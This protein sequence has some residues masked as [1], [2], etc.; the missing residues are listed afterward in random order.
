MSNVEKITLVCLPF[1]G[2]GASFFQEWAD[3]S[4]DITIEAIQ[5][6][7]R[8]KRF[9]EPVYTDVRA[10]SK[11]IFEEF[12][13]NSN[14][15]LNTPLVLFGHSLGAVLAFEV[16]QRFLEAK[17]PLINL[18]VS[19]SPDP[20]TLRTERATGLGDEEFIA[21][22]LEFSE[23][24]HEA[25]E[26]EMMR[27]LLMPALRADVEMHEAY[28]ADP[29]AVV[30]VPVIVLRGSQDSLVST[31][32]VANW[33]SVTSQQVTFEEMDGGHMYFVDKPKALLSLL[34]KNILTEK[35]SMEG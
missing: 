12:Q 23:Y 35:L 16:A 17:L 27:E 14:I 32:Q 3:L 11:G 1:A 31:E 18:V 5:L 2:A 4:E 19:G 28:V 15:D 7:G 21:K 9:I 20:W 25:L 30:D 6:P 24:K 10:A 8:E 33:Q 34:E 26:N 22:V 13:A 29:A